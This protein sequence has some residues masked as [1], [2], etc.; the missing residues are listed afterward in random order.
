MTEVTR[1][2]YKQEV[3]ES[4][5]PVIVDFWGPRCVPCQRLLPLVERWD[6]EEGQP[7]GIKTATVN[8]QQNRMLCVET[9]V[10]SV[11]TFLLVANGKEMQRLTGDVT[12][13][14]VEQLYRQAQALVDG[15]SGAHATT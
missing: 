3:L 2:S 12:A 10:M 9:K 15:G 6:A 14:S 4:L 11:P 1:Q 8:V 7:R 5:Q 13:T